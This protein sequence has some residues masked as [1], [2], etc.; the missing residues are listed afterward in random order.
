VWLYLGII[1]YFCPCYVAGKN[2]EAVG[3]NCCICGIASTLGVIGLLTRTHIR[4]KIREQ[5]G[6]NVSMSKFCIILH[7]THAIYRNYDIVY[8]RPTLPRSDFLKSENTFC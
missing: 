5:K 6:I 7:T 8:G 3:E 1:V 4:G 2:A